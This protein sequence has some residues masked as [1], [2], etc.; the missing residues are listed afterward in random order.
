MI[1]FGV[2]GI[3][4]NFSTL[5]IMILGFASVIIIIQVIS[6]LNK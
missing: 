3:F 4:S 5:A 2:G 6:K 1:S